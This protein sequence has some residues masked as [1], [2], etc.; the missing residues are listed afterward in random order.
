MK[1]DIAKT[2]GSDRTGLTK[3]GVIV[4]S[5]VLRV[6]AAGR[7][8]TPR[9]GL[10][11]LPVDVRQRLGPDRALVDIDPPHVD[12]CPRQESISIPPANIVSM[13]GGDRDKIKVQS[14]LIPPCQYV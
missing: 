13:R 9:A 4:H 14:I 2:G 6:V 8:P 10:S 12:L 5:P 3:R 1:T 11:A 7:Y